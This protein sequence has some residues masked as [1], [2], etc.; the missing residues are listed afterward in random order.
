MAEQESNIFGYELPHKYWFIFWLFWI[1]LAI[2]GVLT[3]TINNNF[4]NILFQFLFLSVFFC[5]LTMFLLRYLGVLVFIK[6]DMFVWRSFFRKYSSDLEAVNSVSYVPFLRIAKIRCGK[7]RLFVKLPVNTNGWDRFLKCLQD[8]TN[9]KKNLKYA[10]DNEF[11]LRE[12][13]FA[14]VLPHGYFELV[15]E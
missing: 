1:N 4:E 14:A 15:E 10:Y 7:D 11:V 9:N 2:A 5:L 12:N 3:L 8:Q 6:D 13:E